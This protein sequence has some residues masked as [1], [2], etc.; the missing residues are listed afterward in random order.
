M[1]KV[2]AA[3]RD[4][5]AGIFGQPIFAPALGVVIRSFTDEVNN[6]YE[7]NM[8]YHHPEDFILFHIGNYDDNTGQ[9]EQIEPIKLISGLEA[10]LPPTANREIT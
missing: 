10:K 5:Q 8:L 7:T 9:I 3:Y 6:K 4:Q 1:K 2:I